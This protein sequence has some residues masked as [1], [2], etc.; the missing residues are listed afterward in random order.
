MS[1]ADK[2]ELKKA[3]REPTTMTVTE[4]SKRCRRIF[5]K[6]N[7]MVILLSYCCN[8]KMIFEY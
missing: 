3:A 6:M 5:N 8:I 1:A 7:E 2:E 4:Q